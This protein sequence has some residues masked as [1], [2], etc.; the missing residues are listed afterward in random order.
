MHNFVKFAKQQCPD[1]CKLLPSPVT[2]A[3]D[4][5][6]RS[7]PLFLGYWNARMPGSNITAVGAGDREADFCM[8]ELF[9]VL[10]RLFVLC[11]DSSDIPSWPSH[12]HCKPPLFIL[13]TIFLIFLLSLSFPSPSWITSPVWNT[14]TNWVLPCQQPPWGWQLTRTNSGCALVWQRGVC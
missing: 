4:G 7:F 12:V 2:A 11:P 1:G 14:N 8:R 10:T 5:A 3:M 13:S 6:W 9:A